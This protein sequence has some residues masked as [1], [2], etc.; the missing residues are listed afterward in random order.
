MRTHKTINPL[1]LTLLTAVTVSGCAFSSGFKYSK[2]NNEKRLNLRFSNAKAASIFYQSFFENVDKTKP[3]NEIA[4]YLKVDSA[5]EIHNSD[6]VKLNYAFRSADKNKNG[7][8]SEKEA[9]AY[10]QSLIKIQSLIKK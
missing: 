7:V 6:N 8:V 2:T 4:A 1:L 10:V 5:S 3:S 9:V